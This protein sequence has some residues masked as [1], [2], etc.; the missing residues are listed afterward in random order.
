MPRPILGVI[1]HLREE[2]R[3]GKGLCWVFDFELEQYRPATHR[4]HWEQLVEE[5]KAAVPWWD[6]TWDQSA[7]RW[8]VK[9]DADYEIA[10]ARIFTNFR[11]AVARLHEQGAL[12]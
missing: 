12:F 4:E 7:R 11:E 8:A 1:K 5:I 3:D 6:R 2:E 10:L 9:V